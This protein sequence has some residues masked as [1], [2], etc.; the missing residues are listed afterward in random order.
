M[1]DS[2]QLRAKYTRKPAATIQSSGLISRTLP[3]AVRRTTHAM[4]PTPM[5]LA[6]E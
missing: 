4:K 2:I 3:A 1:S 6:I 5:P